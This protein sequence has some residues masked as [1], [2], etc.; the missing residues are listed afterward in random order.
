MWQE[1]QV[2]SNIDLLVLTSTHNQWSYL[3]QQLLP[4]LHI[5]HQRR[6]RLLHITHTKHLLDDLKSMRRK[7]RQGIQNHTNLDM[8]SSP[9]P[10][11]LHISHDPPIRI[12]TGPHR[13]S[14]ERLHY[15]LSIRLQTLDIIETMILRPLNTTSHF[16]NS[17]FKLTLT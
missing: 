14:E 15:A 8:N 3:L 2:Q 17:T 9:H 12:H 11:I 13:L 10:T 16:T 6:P 7:R 1:V 4:R 5:I